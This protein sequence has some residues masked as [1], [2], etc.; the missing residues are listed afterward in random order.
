[1][2]DVRIS[3]RLTEEE[4]SKLKVLSIKRKKSIQSLMYDY[5]KREIKKEDKKN[6]EKN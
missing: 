2:K 4:H 5:I 1:M 3:I 6:D